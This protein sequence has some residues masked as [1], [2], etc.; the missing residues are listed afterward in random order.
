M[1]V[2]V[3]KGSTL[4][5]QNNSYSV[6]SRL[7]GEQ[8]DIRLFGEAVEVRFG[9]RLMERMPQLHG[10][11]KHRIEERHVID[12]LVRKPGAFAHY[13][14]R[15]D[16]FPTHRFRMA[17]DALRRAHKAPLKADKAY[18]RVLH[19]A[20]KE[21]EAG[22]EPAVSVLLEGKESLTAEAVEALLDRTL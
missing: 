11:S 6:P 19:L 20:A 8:V 14:Y 13:R 10:R 3:S 17:Y 12:S 4:R 1:R 21:S 16:L 22:V 7:I 2:Q 18:L 9:Q 15:A 5:V